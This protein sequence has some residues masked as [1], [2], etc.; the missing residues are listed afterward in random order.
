MGETI[1]KRKLEGELHHDQSDTE[2][3]EKI[4]VTFEFCDLNPID[5]HAIK[6]LISQLFRIDRSSSSTLEETTKTSPSVALKPSK[7]P[8][9]PVVEDL[10]VGELADLILGE[11]KEWVGCTV[12]C[13]EEDCDPYAFA[14]VL[15]LKFYQQKPSVLGLTRYLSAV[16]HSSAR[17]STQ[18]EELLG[19]FEESL[20]PQGNG[21]GLLLSERLINM[22][23]QVIP[24]LLVQLGNE[25]KHA[26]SKNAPGL[27]FDKVLIPSRVFIVPSG[28]DQKDEINPT[29]EPANNHHQQ[30]D[31]NKKN[32]LEVNFDKD[33]GLYHPED[34]IISQFASHTI[35]FSLGKTEENSR[36]LDTNNEAFGNQQ[37]GILMLISLSKWD[38]MVK[39]LQDYIGDPN[40]HQVHETN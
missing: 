16:L 1:R 11:Q 24:Q 5:Y 34:E 39:R 2:M 37:E 38:E 31:S 25:I 21:I 33:I 13:D 4:D 30:Q 17:S 9:K 3:N 19:I 32:K 26:Q 28:Q 40:T 14:S 23:V 12:K 10:D 22:P 20:K 36:S 7:A 27:Q 6:H 18:A 35:R 29:F 15:D 8:L